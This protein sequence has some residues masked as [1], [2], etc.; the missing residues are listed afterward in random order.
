MWFISR[1][2]AA[3]YSGYSV[4]QWPANPDLEV[5]TILKTVLTAVSVLGCYWAMLSWH[6]VKRGQRDGIRYSNV[7]LLI[8]WWCHRRFS[9]GQVMSRITTWMR[10]LKNY[11]SELKWFQNKVY[12]LY[13]DFKLNFT[14]RAKFYTN[15]IDPKCL[16]VLYISNSNDI[17][18]TL[19]KTIKC[20]S[21]KKRFT[22]ILSIVELLPKPRYH[23]ISQFTQTRLH[24][25]LRLMCSMTLYSTPWPF[26]AITNSYALQYSVL[27]LVSISALSR[28]EKKREIWQNYTDY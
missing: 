12:L 5:H 23:R 27:I 28:E 3:G 19:I 21:K 15:V 14:F 11:N 20:R 8:G 6:G 24:I 2:S 4:A 10:F 17:A 25:G 1:A 18:F 9:E 7:T 22:I 13:C 16:T 26:S